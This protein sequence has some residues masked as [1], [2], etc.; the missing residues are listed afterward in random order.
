[1]DLKEAVKKEVDVAIHGQTWKFR[2]V[3]YAVLFAIGVGVYL[4]GGWSGVGATFAVLLVLS[5]CI[6]FFYRH[7]TE[8][9]SKAWGG[10]TPR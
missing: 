9:W 7:K 3:K 5:I 2:L 4:W 1:M 8:R 6:H 10:Y